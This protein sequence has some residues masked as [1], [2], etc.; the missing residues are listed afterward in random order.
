MEAVVSVVPKT[1]DYIP[2]IVADAATQMAIDTE[3][4]DLC[5]RNPNSAYLRFYRMSPPAVTIGRHQSWRSVVDPERCRQQGWDWV[6]RPTGG[7]ALLHQHELNYAAALSHDI[8]GRHPAGPKLE[9]FARIAAGLMAGL[10]LAGFEARLN[11]SRKSRGTDDILTA[12]G[13]CGAS[14]TRF[15]ITV[16][17]LKAVA[18]A[19]CNLAN[20]SLQHGTIYLSP[21]G[22]GDCFWPEAADPSAIGQHW[23]AWS[24]PG[25]SSEGQWL[26]AAEMLKTGLSQNLGI[27]WRPNMFDWPKSPAVVS[28]IARWEAEQWHHHR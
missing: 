3:L 9:I 22:A 27:E 14:L 18:A 15:E 13:L 7:G 16:N 12:H 11:P 6:R 5:N 2:L 21:P 17:G 23:W 1:W 20:A 26:A 25:S 24:M 10:S 19:Q 28:R 8:M 4:A